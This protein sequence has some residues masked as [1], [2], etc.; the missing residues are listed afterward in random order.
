MSSATCSGR[1]SA[2]PRSEEL[3]WL[4]ALGAIV[5]APR[6]VQLAGPDAAIGLR[7]R[8]LPS[9][10]VVKAVTGRPCP[11]CG[12]TRGV[13]YMT[14]RDVRNAGRANRFAP[15]VFAAVCARA[16]LAATRLARWARPEMV[17][18]AGGTRTHKPLRA[19]AFE[20]A[21]FTKLDTAASGPSE[22]F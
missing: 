10:C 9:L 22:R 6:I 4:A 19:A 2:R 15:L 20:T 21:S 7:G 13:L 18:A 5:L 17:S 1:T 12:M 8:E 3:A 14:R 11:S 16:L